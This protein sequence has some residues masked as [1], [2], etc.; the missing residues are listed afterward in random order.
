MPRDFEIIRRQAFEAHAVAALPRLD[1]QTGM[2]ASH[3]PPSS[4]AHS[5]AGGWDIR[6]TSHAALALAATGRD[7]PAWKALR[8][9]LDHQDRDPASMTYGNFFWHSNWTTALDPNAASFIVPGLCYTLAHCADRLP[10]ALAQDLRTCLA[11]AVEG[12]N[13]HRATWGYTNIALLNMAAKLM[14]AD[15]LDNSRARKIAYWDWEEWR[16][17]TVRLATIPEY[18]SLSYTTVQ[19]DALAMMLACKTCEA[20]QREVRN[21]MR[22]L[23]ASVAADYHPAVGRVTGPQ[24][25]AYEADRRLRGHGAIDGVLH[26]VLGTPVSA[27]GFPLW[28]GVPIGPDDLR[29]EV[30][31]LPLPR[32]TS[33]EN[34]GFRRFNYLAPDFALG[35]VSG[36][37]HLYGQ[38]VP[39]FVA[40]RAKSPRCTVAFLEQY[41]QRATAHFSDQREGALLAVSLFLLS[42]RAAPAQQDPQWWEGKLTELNTGRPGDLVDDPAFRP[43]YTVEIGRAGEVGVVNDSGQP[44]RPAAP[45]SSPVLAVDAESVCI[46]MRFFSLRSAPDLSLREDPDGEWVLDARGVR[47]GR[48]VSAVE[49]AAWCGCLLYVEPKGA[50]VTAAGLARRMASCRI[51]VT[52][53]DAGWRIHAPALDGSDLRVEINAAPPTLY[54]VPGWNVTPNAWLSTAR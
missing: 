39:F 18:N 7:E 51:D 23:I 50:G 40:F 9:V 38:D 12:L 29:P 45:I 10:P 43:G 15:V 14:I 42:T 36:R 30:R 22:H 21:A 3:V 27:A 32:A 46:G 13:A 19:I 44:L 25:R 26:V 4:G 54:A 2:I 28:L 24:S 5:R 8:G 16:N 11:R 49:H 1:A 33:A 6:A 52:A 41:P 48:D 34:H 20:F 53:T 17:H 31:N 37:H 35:S 47:D